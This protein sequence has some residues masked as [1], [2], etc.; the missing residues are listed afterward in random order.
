MT[1]FKRFNKVIAT[2]LCAGLIG[3]T[4]SALAPAAD[5]MG[6]EHQRRHDLRQL[7]REMRRNRRSHRP[8]RRAYHRGLNRYPHVMPAYGSTPGFGIQLVF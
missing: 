3:T 6:Y 5:A 1:T 2:A 8:V 7:R 4:A